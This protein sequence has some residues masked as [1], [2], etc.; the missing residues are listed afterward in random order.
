MKSANSKLALGLL[1]GVAVG[2]ILGILFAPDKGSKTRRKILDKRQELTDDLKN[3]Y[4]GLV[5]A[6]AKKY[7]K[8]FQEGEDLLAD[9]KAKYEDLKAEGKSQYEDLKSE[10]KAKLGEAKQ[11]FNS[12]KS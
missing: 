4:S 2:A 3:K 1:G 9:G 11:E 10:G 7:D 8:L 12:L 6:A 5:G